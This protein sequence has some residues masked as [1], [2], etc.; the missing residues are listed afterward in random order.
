MRQSLQKFFL[1]MLHVLNASDVIVKYPKQQTLQK[2]AVCSWYENVLME[3]LQE[4][5]ITG[6]KTVGM[7]V[8]NESLL[9]LKK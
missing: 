3:T 6:T 9:A 4:H 8:V 2:G 1:G 7:S 5:E